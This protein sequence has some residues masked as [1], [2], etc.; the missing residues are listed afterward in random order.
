MG[1]RLGRRKDQGKTAHRYPEVGAFLKAR[2]LALRIHKQTTL[3]DRI[4][5]IDPLHPGADFR[6]IS[7]WETGAHLPSADHVLLRALE[8]ATGDPLHAEW[9]RLYGDGPIELREHRLKV[10]TET[11]RYLKWVVDQFERLDLYGLHSADRRSDIKLEQVFVALRGGLG[12]PYQTADE[13]LSLQDIEDWVDAS[14]AHAA[15]AEAQVH[16]EIPIDVEERGL[17]RMFGS[18]VR[19]TLSLGEAFRREARLVILGDPGSGKTTLLRWLALTLAKAS[20]EP[21][22]DGVVRV[23]HHCVDPNQDGDTTQRLFDLGPARLPVYVRIATFLEHRRRAGR[24]LAFE[25]HLGHH[26]SPFGETPHAADGR[27][28]DPEVLNRS[29]REAIRQGQVVLLLDG[30]DEIADPADR[31]PIARAVESFLDNILLPQTPPGPAGVGNQVIVTS[32]IV[33][34]QMAGLGPRSTH[35]T[36]EPMSS[37]AIDR[38]CRLYTRERARANSGLDQLTVALETRASIEAENIIE[39]VAAL[40]RRGSQGLTSTPLLL[41]IL[42][43][44]SKPGGRLPDFRAQLYRQAVERII[45]TWRDR[46]L[47]TGNDTFPDAQRLEVYLS[48]LAYTLQTHSG[49]GVIDRDEACSRLDGLGP[50]GEIRAFIACASQEVGLLTARGVDAIGFQHQT[51][52]EYFAARWLIQD[53][54]ATRAHIL[55]RAQSP[56]WRE[57]ILLALGLLS[58]ERTGPD[59][60]SSPLADILAELA[61]QPGIGPASLPSEFL[62]AGRALQEC[63]HLPAGVVSQIADRA[64]VARMQGGPEATSLALL[65]QL[66]QTIGYLNEARVRPHLVEALRRAL[67]GG[68][69]EPPELALGAAALAP[70]AGAT[71]RVLVQA[72]QAALPQDSG[73]WGWPIDTALRLSAS[74]D[75][76]QFPT[77]PRAL[78]TVLMQSDDY[79]RRFLGS[80]AGR[81]LAWLI[82]GG[83]DAALPRDLAAARAETAHLRERQQRLEALDRTP[84]LQLGIDDIGAQTA[85]V[86]DRIKAIIALGSVISTDRM[87]RDAPVVTRLVLEALARGDDL[88]S[89]CPQLEALLDDTAAPL[90]G[91]ADAALALLALSEDPTDAFERRVLGTGLER[92]VL[93]GLSRTFPNLSLAVENTGRRAI[94][95]ACGAEGFRENT[96]IIEIVDALLA[97]LHWAGGLPLTIADALDV[98]PPFL[99]RRIMAEV[100]A[101][102]LTAEYHDSLYN[103]SVAL[104][105]LGADLGDPA[106]LCGALNELPTARH[107]RPTA[108]GWMPSPFLPRA[109]SDGEFI[110]LALD[111][112]AEIPAQFSVVSGW[113]MH[114]LGQVFARA[115]LAGEAALVAEHQ[116]APAFGAQAMAVAALARAEPYPPS[117]AMW[118]HFRLARRSRRFS[119][120]AANGSSGVTRYQLGREVSIGA[121]E[122][123]G[124]IEALTKLSQGLLQPPPDQE[125]GFDLGAL[126]AA[127]AV[128]ILLDD[129][130]CPNS[131]AELLTACLGHLARSRDAENSCRALVRLA[132]RTPARLATRFLESATELLATLDD[133]RS[134][135]NLALALEPHLLRLGLSR[136]RLDAVRAGLSPWFRQVA[137]SRWHRAVRGASPWIDAAEVDSS[138]LDLAALLHDIEILSGASLAPVRPPS[139]SLT[140]GSPLAPAGEA[141]K[142]QLDLKA[143]R[144][145]EALASGGLE[146]L[147]TA[148]SE[149]ASPTSDALPMIAAWDQRHPELHNLIALLRAEVHGLRSGLVTP[150]FEL[151]DDDDDLTRCR[152]A[153]ALYGRGAGDPWRI[154]ISHSGPAI[155]EEIAGLMAQSDHPLTRDR[156]RGLALV[157]VNEAIV[158][159]DPLM[160]ADWI[161][162]LKGD[163]SPEAPRT[164]AAYI[165]RNINH[166]S[167]DVQLILIGALDGADQDLQKGLLKSICR[168]AGRDELKPESWQALAEAEPHILEAVRKQLTF[169]PA[170]ADYSAAALRAEA[171]HPLEL[172]PADNHPMSL[173]DRFRIAGELQFYGTVYRQQIR[174]AADAVPV[175]VE[176]YRALID[177]LLADLPAEKRAEQGLWSA[178]SEG[179]IITAAAVERSPQTF[180]QAL[181]LSMRGDRPPEVS[182]LESLLIDA[183]L[184]DFSFTGRAAAIMLLSQL[185]WLSPG[186]CDAI[187]SG[188]RD[189]AY[190]QSVTIASIS[191]FRFATSAAVEILRSTLRDPAGPA[192]TKALCAELLVGLAKNRR[193]G[194]DFDAMVTETLA[195]AAQVAPNRRVC[196]LLPLS[197]N[198]PHV[199]VSLGRLDLILVTALTE[200]GEINKLSAGWPMLGNVE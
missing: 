124:V 5:A 194:A 85:L 113:M 88:G 177:R 37:R 123:S 9:V 169:L 186:V 4:E 54:V 142:G 132:E 28:L 119:S 68:G 50:P 38:Y 24:A 42:I 148:L 200:P 151:L 152:A 55:G 103:V 141:G 162:E 32:R 168:L 193:L 56:R 46:I 190:V 111:T 69:D 78:R 52:Q 77:D 107:A 92:P 167:L 125:A 181:G 67:S 61:G 72:L 172:F 156:Q 97:S 19:E 150:L 120:A 8:I 170:M 171:P 86:G 35:M 7:A 59:A 116:I 83:M 108:K 49:L 45:D 29:I 1:D 154:R 128:E 175:T 36:L 136:D 82:Y 153:M 165:V 179:L 31:A 80:P 137:E 39:Q 117:D 3:A 105:T 127:F 79:R 122:D 176:G 130:A 192:L 126:E 149:A 197:S 30:L 27:P 13:A 16:L 89:L 110:C 140:M 60:G 104:D 98:A 65:R 58:L 135:A 129:P 48:H 163:A 90:S 23:P 26:L 164:A 161:A 134:L 10:D 191:R 112:L 143:V 44:V 41:T 51:F 138:P 109:R 100:W 43:M 183:A 159:D 76:H 87:H 178:A 180:V 21:T 25:E 33:G 22:E 158:Y 173:Q 15:A 75:P 94:H 40:A 91:R 115:G 166:A 174:D 18:T 62:L 84:E 182:R 70:L 74:H 147:R 106:D 187:T 145:I 133:E 20:L 185:R 139:A 99:K 184:H 53:R 160:V 189:V 71:D 93:D 34:Y 96:A 17:D 66:A 95:A 6:N 64:I 199:I 63:A 14:E 12:N 155:V 47:R 196:A 144:R 146:A 198:G 195:E 118:A 11:R 114:Q 101:F 73:A 121:D 157:W 2:R 81:R 188:L 131:G 102:M 57:P